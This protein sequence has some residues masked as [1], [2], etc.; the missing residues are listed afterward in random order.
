MEKNIIDDSDIGETI[1]EATGTNGT[2]PGD[3][4]TGNNATGTKPGDNQTGNNATGNPNKILELI[5]ID[6]KTRFLM[7][8]I[9]VR[10][11]SSA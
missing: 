7:C 6:D 8:Q 3:N 9:L 5:K 10:A 1:K 11:L 2:K 4:Q